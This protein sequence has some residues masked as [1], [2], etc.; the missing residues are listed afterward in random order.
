VSYTTRTNFFDNLRLYAGVRNIFD[1]MGPFIPYAGDTSLSGAGNSDSYYGGLVGRF[2]F[3]G[4]EVIF[5]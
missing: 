2:V 3:I 4:A 1:D 5:D